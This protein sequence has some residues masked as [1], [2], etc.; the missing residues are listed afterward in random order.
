MRI[1]AKE[2]LAAKGGL[3]L[4]A[5]MF[6]TV[7]IPGRTLDETYQIPRAVV[8]YKNTVFVAHDKRLKTVPVQVARV[9]GDYAYISGGLQNGDRVIVTRLVDPLENILLEI[10]PD[11]SMR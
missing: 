2:A 3:P 9:D 1:D 8:S 4:V 7:E 6:C 11:Q 5:G 10:M